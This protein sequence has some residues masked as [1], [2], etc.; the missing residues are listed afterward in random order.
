MNTDI[1]SGIQDYLFTD[2]GY[3]GIDALPEM[4]RDDA[5]VAV[6][7]VW[8]N[9]VS[10]EDP[11]D[12]PLFTAHRPQTYIVGGGYPDYTKYYSDYHAGVIGCAQ[13]VRPVLTLLDTP[14]LTEYQYQF[15]IS[16]SGKD[17]FCTQ[18]TGSPLEVNT[19]DY[20]NASPVQLSL[21]QLLRSMTRIF[22]ITDGPISN[23]LKAS[24]TMSRGVSPGLS[25][26]Q[27]IKE[28]VG[29]ESL[30]WAAYQTLLSTSIIGP[31]VFDKHAEEYCDV[32]TSS[33]D[34]ELCRSLKMRKS[35]GFA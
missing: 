28:V 33:G 10:Y 19:S 2:P 26:D 30:V 17:D 3:I 31:K 22:Q 21:L 34:K 8:M 35:G 11:V 4:Q 16:Q 23:Q 27:W 9:N 7:A 20:P 5:D 14:W 25:P 32:P 1:P 29:W 15:C 18:L 12:D 13:Q 6:I 24:S